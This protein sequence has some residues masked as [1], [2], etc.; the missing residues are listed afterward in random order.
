MHQQVAKKSY[1]K[2]LFK[3]TTIAAK[4]DFNAVKIFFSVSGREFFFQEDQF[5]PIIF[6]N[7]GLAEMECYVRKIKNRGLV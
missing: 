2:L 1:E 4:N 3:M 6:A 7:L 5:C